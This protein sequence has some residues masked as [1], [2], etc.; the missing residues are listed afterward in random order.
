MIKHLSDHLMQP[1][2]PNSSTNSS[3]PHGPLIP[4]L[5]YL[6]HT[7]QGTSASTSVLTPTTPSSSETVKK[8]AAPTRD[9]HEWT[10][11]SESDDTSNKSSNDLKETK[12]TE[13]SMEN[14][15]KAHK[16]QVVDKAQNDFAGSS[17]N[18]LKEPTVI[19]KAV[20]QTCDALESNTPDSKGRIDQSSSSGPKTTTEA[21]EDITRGL[22]NYS[23][24]DSASGPANGRISETTYSQPPTATS[25][26]AHGVTGGSKEQSTDSRASKN[27]QEKDANGE[28]LQSKVETPIKKGTSAGAYDDKLRDILINSKY[29]SPDYKPPPSRK[30]TVHN[31]RHVGIGRQRSGA[32]LNP[33]AAEILK[34]TGIKDKELRSSIKAPINGNTRLAPASGAEAANSP[35][36]YAPP[37]RPSSL[38][39]HTDEAPHPPMCPH[40]QVTASPPPP[41][42]GDVPAPTQKVNRPL[43]VEKRDAISHLIQ[44]AMERAESDNQTKAPSATSGSGSSK[45][46]VSAIEHYALEELQAL[47]DEANNEDK[48]LNELKELGEDEIERELLNEIDACSDD[49][50]RLLAKYV[51]TVFHPT[52]I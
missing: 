22:R 26:D 13:S 16:K 43:T 51:T 21:I 30:A 17:S 36:S 3:I 25:T 41:P 35:P 23:T 10:R 4:T 52:D 48:V 18:V 6:P 9:P 45:P 24:N 12:G 32:T 34:D 14:S 49:T 19:V 1:V 2:D 8:R 7:P 39:G 28:K 15:D 5:H 27:S 37:K 20:N 40:P 29:L 42:P 47:L 31:F 46:T 50:K 33:Q 11:V 38:C 44:S